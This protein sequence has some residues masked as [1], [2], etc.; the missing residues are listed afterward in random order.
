[1]TIAQ[2]NNPSVFSIL[3]IAQGKHY[4]NIR[5]GDNL[6]PGQ[7]FNT[8]NFLDWMNDFESHLKLKTTSTQLMS[9]AVAGNVLIEQ[10]QELASREVDGTPSCG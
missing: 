2:R 8:R 9:I 6:N 10:V 5:T 7:T 3:R 4:F 1:M